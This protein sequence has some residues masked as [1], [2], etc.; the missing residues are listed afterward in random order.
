MLQER[1]CILTSR[2]TGVPHSVLRLGT[3]PFDHRFNSVTRILSRPVQALVSS[4]DADGPRTSQLPCLV[5]V[6]HQTTSQQHPLYA[7]LLWRLHLTP[8]PPCGGAIFLVNLQHTWCFWHWHTNGSV[9]AHAREERHRGPR[10]L[11]LLLSG[12]AHCRRLPLFVST[13]LEPIGVDLSRQH[14]SSA[15][16]WYTP[17]LVALHLG[18]SCCKNDVWIQRSS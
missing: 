16:S 14:Y 6:V 3:E 7:V 18:N 17:R 1:E 2:N 13:R 5:A 8:L 9:A 10:S 12:F 11:P 15:A 4:L